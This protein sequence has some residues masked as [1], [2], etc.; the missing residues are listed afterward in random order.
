M[1]TLKMKKK[2][3]SR[4]SQL[5]FVVL[6]SMTAMTACGSSS[7]PSDEGQDT[8]ASNQTVSE[9]GISAEPAFLSRGC[10]VGTDSPQGFCP[11]SGG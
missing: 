11:P 10:V 6:V 5:L 3:V 4:L 7:S 2:D 1:Q 8:G 9:F